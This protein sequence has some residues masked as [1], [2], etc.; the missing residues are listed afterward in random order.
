MIFGKC[1]T[2]QVINCDYRCNDGVKT[3]N[4]YYNKNISSLER[5]ITLN[6]NFHKEVEATPHS[7]FNE[8]QALEKWFLGCTKQWLEGYK[9]EVEQFPTADAGSIDFRDDLLTILDELLASISKKPV[10]Q[11]NP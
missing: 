8:V 10:A 7:P 5:I 6:E 11:E 2:C 1:T 9:A 3:C 4:G